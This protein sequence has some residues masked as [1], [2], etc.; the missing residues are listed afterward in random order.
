[1]DYQ[2]ICN[3]YVA[4]INPE[5]VR[6][7]DNLEPVQLDLGEE[8]QMA[9]Y[10]RREGLGALIWWRGGRSLRGKLDFLMLGKDGSL[11]MA[12]ATVGNLYGWEHSEKA[13]PYNM[14][15]SNDEEARSRWLKWYEGEKAARDGA[16]SFATSEACKRLGV[17]RLITYGGDFRDTEIDDVTL[18]GGYCCED[19]EFVTEVCH[20]YR[21][22]LVTPP[23][24]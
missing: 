6:H 21:N 3:L 17:T 1:M 4:P 8:N 7:L 20:G 14:C 23:P 10:R 5:L 16:V 9:V 15:G 12:C 13:P 24:A 2:K 19:P 18:I 22:C 11:I